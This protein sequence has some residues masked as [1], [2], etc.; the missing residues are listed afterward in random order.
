VGNSNVLDDL[1]PYLK[2]NAGVQIFNGLAVAPIDFKNPY[3]RANAVYFDNH[4]WASGYFRACHRDDTFK[5]RWHSAI[6][7]WNDKV[8]VDIG[9]GPGNLFATLGGKPKKLIGVDVSKVALGMA[10]EIGYAPLQADAHNLP[11]VSECADIVALNATLHHCDEMV[12]VLGEAARLVR[13][14]GVLICDHDPQLTAWDWRGL[15]M[16]LYKIRLPLY[17]LFQGHVW[18]EQRHRMASE[19]HH[20]P[21]H[22]VTPALFIS[23]LEPLNF[24]VKLCPHNNS[25]GAETFDLVMGRSKFKYRMGQILSGIDPDSTEGALS[26][27]CIAVRGH[28]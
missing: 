7:S 15:G 23:I 9:C 14:G 12:T 10:R 11:L 22:G 28:R 4:A 6:G 3:T 13:P 27:M 16:L 2:P 25:S 24:D 5:D 1:E 21:G 26:L 8:V 20:R 17:R 18:E 19:T